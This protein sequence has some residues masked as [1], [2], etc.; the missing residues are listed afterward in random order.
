MT[1]LLGLGAAILAAIVG[2][3]L[4]WRRNGDAN[5]GDLPTRI[6]FFL[7]GG[8][9]TTLAWGCMAMRNTGYSFLEALQSVQWWVF[10]IWLALAAT[11]L[12]KPRE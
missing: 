10:G 7:V 2:T 8:V 11:L 3:L 5:F 9:L 4:I 6:G 1:E 12:P